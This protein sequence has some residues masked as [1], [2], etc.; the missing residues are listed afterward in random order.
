MMSEF[1]GNQTQFAAEE[2]LFQKPSV[3]AIPVATPDVVV[4]EPAKQTNKVFITVTVLAVVAVLVGILVI[5]MRPVEQVVVQEDVVA[6]PSPVIAPDSPLRAR[7]TNL[8]SELKDADPATQ[9]LVFPPVD[10]ELT[11]DSIK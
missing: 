6:L 2:P 10:M 5:V 1:D 3:A 4:Q 9:S 7:V 11:L 8:Q